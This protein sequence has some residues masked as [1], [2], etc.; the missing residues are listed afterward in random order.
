M[1]NAALLLLLV[2]YPLRS[3]QFFIP[4]FS[5]QLESEES[6]EAAAQ[7]WFRPVFLHLVDGTEP[8]K[9]NPCIHSEPFVVGK[10]KFA[11]FLLRILQ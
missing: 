1:K 4:N 9:F 3:R 8:D 2:M 10:M 6:I 11:L 7:G 5:Q